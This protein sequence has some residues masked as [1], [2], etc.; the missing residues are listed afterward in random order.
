MSA[1]NVGFDFIVSPG[2]IALFTHIIA[3]IFIMVPVNFIFLTLTKKMVPRFGSLT[4]FLIVYGILAFPT[5]LFGGTPGIYKVVVGLIIGLFL[6]LV[7]LPSRPALQLLLAAILGSIIWWTI[8]FIIWAGFGFAFVIAFASMFNSVIN[9][10][11]L[12]QLPLINFSGDFF[13]F[14]VI[15][16]GLSAA[17]VLIANILGYRVFKRI[18]KTILYEQF[19]GMK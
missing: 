16:G 1:A 10:S 9:I 14:A 7:Y 2:F 5:T 12:I 19:K 18:E 6:D 8:T 15:C 17:P 4:L 11:S 3:G 13:I